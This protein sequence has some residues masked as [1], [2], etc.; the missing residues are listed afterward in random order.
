MEIYSPLSHQV[1]EIIEATRQAVR[2]SL[3]VL[4]ADGQQRQRAAMKRRLH[5]CGVTQVRDASDGP[6]AWALRRELPSTS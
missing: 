3:R 4:P 1:P 6:Q 5:R 2:S